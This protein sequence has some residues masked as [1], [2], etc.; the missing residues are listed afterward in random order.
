MKSIRRA[1]SVAVSPSFASDSTLRGPRIGQCS[2]VP[3]R[4]L[5]GLNAN[6]RWTLVYPPGLPRRP[7]LKAPLEPIAA[8]LRGLSQ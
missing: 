6:R 7:S 8:S 1:S 4:L 3:G 5:R 2:S